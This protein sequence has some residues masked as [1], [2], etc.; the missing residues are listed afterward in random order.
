[1][2]KTAVISL[3]VV[4]IAI[5]I[6]IIYSQIRSKKKKRKLLAE[7]RELGKANNVNISEYENWNHYAIGIDKESAKLIYLNTDLADKGPVIIDL[8]LVKSCEVQDF[9]RGVDTKSGRINVMDLLKLRL[10]LKANDIPPISLEFY[11][12]ETDATPHHETEI[13]AKWKK[14]VEISLN[15]L[16]QNQK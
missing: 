4:S 8:S 13:L 6:P 1:M 12:S 11:N 15:S 5:I 10:T 9:T 16:K 3:I 14:I 2:D 7:F